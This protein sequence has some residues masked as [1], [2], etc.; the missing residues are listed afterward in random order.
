MEYYCRRNISM[1]ETGVYQSEII[2]NVDSDTWQE[3]KC[4]L[5]VQAW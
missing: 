4:E 3:H 2:L 5:R 1:M